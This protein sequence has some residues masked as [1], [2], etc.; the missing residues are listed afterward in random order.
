VFTTVYCKAPPVCVPPPLHSVPIFRLFY[1][2]FF[3]STWPTHQMY[4]PSVLF[5]MCCSALR[6]F[7][8]FDQFMLSQSTLVVPPTRHFLFCLKFGSFFLDFFAFPSQQGPPPA[9]LVIFVFSSL[10]RHYVP[11]SSPPAIDI[12]YRF[13]DGSCPDSL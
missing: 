2:P 7:F 3:A 9:L 12:S 8:A 6:F 5:A 13:L 10:S 11:F 4:M 1:C